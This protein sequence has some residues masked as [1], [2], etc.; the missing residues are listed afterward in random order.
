MNSI[1]TNVACIVAIYQLFQVWQMR[2]DSKVTGN[3]KKGFA[4][5]NRCTG[6]VRT[7]EQNQS[8]VRSAGMTEYLPCQAAARFDKEI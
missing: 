8:R 2:S 6:S 1:G 7:A 5:A 3:H 4:L